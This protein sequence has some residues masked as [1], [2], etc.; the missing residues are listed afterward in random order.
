MTACF[1]SVKG[2][3][4]VMVASFQATDSILGAVGM[5]EKLVLAESVYPAFYQTDRD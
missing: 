2:A 3:G 5:Q 1:F 4:V